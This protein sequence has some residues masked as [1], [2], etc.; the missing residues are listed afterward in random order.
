[1]RCTVKNHQINDAAKKISAKLMPRWKGPFKIE[2]FLT[3]VDVKLVDLHTG[4]YVTRAHV[5]HLKSGSSSK[6]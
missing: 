5:S 1:M 2:E 4:K 6:D 3:R